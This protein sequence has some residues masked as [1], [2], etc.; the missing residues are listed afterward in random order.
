L[1]CESIE[2]DEGVPL[3]PNT[4]LRLQVCGKNF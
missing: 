3:I 1:L 2:V 4:S